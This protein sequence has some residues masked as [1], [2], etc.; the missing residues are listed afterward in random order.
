MTDL[1][2]M[3]KER[4]AK[5]GTSLMDK[6]DYLAKFNC[7]ISEFCQLIEKAVSNADTDYEH[8]FVNDIAQ[9]Y[10]LY[11]KGIFLTENSFNKLKEISNKQN[12]SRQM[13]VI[14]IKITKYKTGDGR[15]FDD[16]DDAIVHDKI[17]AI[18]ELLTD[19][20]LNNFHDNVPV[21][22]FKFLNKNRD[23]I[24]DMMGWDNESNS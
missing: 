16:K 17:N 13:S 9:R 19:E 2:K 18:D 5:Q 4:K 8:R 6:D 20:E 11:G 15:I 14:E 1:S 7:K 10:S 22:L 21:N 12:G 24:V 23:A 3:W